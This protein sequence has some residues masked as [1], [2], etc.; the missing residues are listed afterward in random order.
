MTD[1]IGTAWL[2][3]R[4]LNDGVVFDALRVV[5]DAWLHDWVQ[6]PKPFALQSDTDVDWSDASEGSLCIKQGDVGFRISIAPL[7][8]VQLAEA[9]LSARWV[10]RRFAGT[11]LRLL[12]ALSERSAEDLGRRLVRSLGLGAV[13]RWDDAAPLS[14]RLQRCSLYFSGNPKAMLQIDM[15]RAFCVALRKR[16]CRPMRPMKP[17]GSL[18]AAVS[19]EMT[20][21]GG[22]IG[23][24][25]VT[26]AELASLRS[27][28]V[29]VLDR[30]VGATFDL[31]INGVAT[32]TPA[33]VRAGNVDARLS[34]VRNRVSAA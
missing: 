7:G 4:A 1:Q 26:M 17:I 12:R 6:A 3:E 32:S 22:Y 11:D 13:E 18:A 28:D 9:I 34:S 16:H 19:G 14:G 5:V 20:S 24:G 15:D 8:Q 30:A 21:I 27:G 29:L 2:P 23:A 33:A 10:W 31:T 25:A